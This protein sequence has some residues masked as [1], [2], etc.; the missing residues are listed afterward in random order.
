MRAHH[1][2]AASWST[3]VSY[4][5]VVKTPLPAF[6]LRHRSLLDCVYP[7]SYSNS[8]HVKQTQSMAHRGFHAFILCVAG[9]CCRQRF[10][11]HA[12]HASSHTPGSWCLTYAALGLGRD[13][14]NIL[15]S[16]RPESWALDDSSVE[17]TPVPTQISRYRI[18]RQIP[19]Y[20]RT[21][22]FRYL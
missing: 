9:S 7:P 8:N 6:V 17:K 14:A 22:S 3:A 16:S 12:V 19:K 13:E 20:Q 4:S 2:I 1:S 11:A 18:K 10:L 21:R 5:S 15:A